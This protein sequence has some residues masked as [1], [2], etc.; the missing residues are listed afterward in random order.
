MATG[1]IPKLGN[2]HVGNACKSIFISDYTGLYSPTNLGGWNNTILDPN[3]LITSVVTTSIIITRPDNTSTTILNPVGI[4]N[5][6]LTV[7]YEIIA[8]VLNI[9]NTFIP[10]GL[11]QIEYIIFD[12]TDTYT[13]G[14]A[15]YLFTCNIGCCVSKL[16]SKIAESS[17]I[18]CNSTV[19]K[20]ALYASA[21]YHGLIASKDCGNITAINSLISKLNKI[22]NS[23]GSNCGCV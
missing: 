20:N 13:T 9:G 15:Y 12:G 6:L 7:E 14:K 8:P 21:L 4:P 16:F 1:L 22:C 10:D 19:I 17:D 11:Y 2:V 3:I 5:T 18:S 23:A